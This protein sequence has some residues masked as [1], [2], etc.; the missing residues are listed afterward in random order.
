MNRAREEKRARVW[1][2]MQVIGH[3]RY[4]TQGVLMW[5]GGYAAAN[6]VLPLLNR[7]GFAFG[8]GMSPVD[9]LICGGITGAVAAELHWSD[10]KRKFRNPPPQEDWMAR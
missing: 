6:G 5:I 2:T 7:I 3:R 10:M 1:E 4:L 8:S 9:I